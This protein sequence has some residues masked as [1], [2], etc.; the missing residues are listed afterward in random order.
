[1]SNRFFHS[2]AACFMGFVAFS[3]NTAPIEL[4]ELVIEKIKI[5]A[6]SKS[7]NLVVLNDSLIENS[8]GTFTDF[9]QKNTT[10]YFKESGYGMVSSPAF[11]GTTA[12]QTSVL[13]N[14]IRVNSA[15]LGQSDFNATAFK[16]YDNIVVKAGGGSVLYG[17]SAIGGTIH[18]N[19]QLQF[20]RKTENE[21]QLHYGSFNTQSIHYKITTGFDKFAVNAHFGY[22]KSDNDYEWIG[23]NRKN[24]NGQ[25]YN[26]N[27]GLEAAYK[28]NRKNTL[29]FYSTTYNDDR[30]FALLTPFQTKTKYQN[31]NYRNLL[32]WHFKTN[33]FLNT[34]YAAVLNES[35]TYFDQ[36]PTNSKSGGKAN[37]L[38]F[39]NESFYNV[40]QH[41]KLSGFVEY[42]KTTGEGQ[43][44]SLPFST[45][46][47]FAVSVLGNYEFT[48]RFGME[49]GAKNEMAKDY[50]NP[51]LFSA[52]FFYNSPFYQLKI[53]TSKNYRIPTFNDLYWQPGGNLNL[54]PETSL[55]LDVNQNFIF[56]NTR[57]NVSAYTISIKDMIRWIPTNSGFWEANNV[58]EVRV[59]GI[60]FFANYQK[61][62][63]YHV[64]ELQANY[65]YTQSI[66]Q[67]TKKQLTYTPLH[68]LNAQLI[69]KYRNFSVSPSFLYVGKIY[70]TASNTAASALNSYGI[71]DVDFQQ[72]FNL[73]NNPFYIN[74]KIKNAA[75][76]V[77]TNMPERVMPG[78]NIH[79]QL[80]KKF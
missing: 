18:L 79:L 55:Q 44:S 48:E 74:L 63:A 1:M 61:K 16:S 25:F 62:W 66:D 4:D 57:M 78:R 76:T 38:Y 77:Y 2:L 8:I 6:Q 60:D 13:W 53:N 43:N 27:F 12:Q 17:S 28:I 21:L 54:K 68:K 11:R 14:G 23:K 31:N 5:S 33:T 7:Q 22:N 37:T 49:A 47:I 73:K 35:Y 42:Q 45:Q 64:V 41:F 10:I 71:I 51:F 29:S 30:H 50:S 67:T 80:I 75:N 36:L 3:Q 15:L 70:T 20:N 59:F 52:G 34:F 19:N 39:K 46:E 26:T 40:L 32:K 65:G 56:K 9:L 69:Y 24:I 72:K 58:D